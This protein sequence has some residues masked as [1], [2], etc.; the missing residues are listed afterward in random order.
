MTKVSRRPRFKVGDCVRMV[1]QPVE[2][3]LEDLPKGVGFIIQTDFGCKSGLEYLV[4]FPFWIK[5]KTY[6][7][8]SQ[9]W[10]EHKILK[11]VE[12]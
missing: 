7:D 5:P 10:C 9:W 11:L 6:I 1:L 4:R 3:R 8:N 2:L 12:D